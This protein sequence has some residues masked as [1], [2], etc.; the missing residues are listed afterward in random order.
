LLRGQ[1]PARS[2]PS[3]ELTQPAMER[4][5]S[6]GPFRTEWFEVSEMEPGVHL[7]SEP[8]HVNSW[9]I[10]GSKSAVLFD[11]GLGVADIRKVAEDIT[12]HKLLVVNSHYHFDHTGGNRLFDEFAIHRFGG[13]LVSKLSPPELAAGYMAYTQR[14]LDAWGPYREADDLYFHL[15]T[16]ERMIRQLPE[17]FAPGDYKVVPTIPTRLLE[18]GDLLDLGGRKLQVLH[19]PGHSPDCICLL[20]EANGLLFGGDTI[21]TG[22]IYAQMEESDLEKFALSTARLAEMAE[23]YRRVFVCHFLRFDEPA[24]LVREIAAGFKELL[25]GGAFIRD[26]VDCFNY[27]VKEACF[28]HF[29]IF[30]PAGEPTRL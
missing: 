11:T 21:N 14:L 9:L 7:I 6:A 2:K 27:P 12:P 5:T 15:L 10:E 8:G 29:S 28:E 17:G 4:G 16:A 13:D 3:L 18:E 20:D 26:N 30:I 22:P 24:A 1:N 25:A 23:G 19:T